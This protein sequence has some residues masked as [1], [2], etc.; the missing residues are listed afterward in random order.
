MIINYYYFL[1]AFH[2]VKDF[3]EKYTFPKNLSLTLSINF[4]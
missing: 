3:S 2:G 4:N 1:F